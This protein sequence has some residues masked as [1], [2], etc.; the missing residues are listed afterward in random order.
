VKAVR[1]GYI[2][3]AYVDHRERRL[4]TGTSEDKAVTVGSE[5][6]PS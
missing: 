5:E 3:G 4:V 6:V 2:Q 1:A